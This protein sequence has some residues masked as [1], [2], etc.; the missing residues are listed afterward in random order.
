MIVQAAAA[1]PHMYCTKILH[2][3]QKLLRIRARIEKIDDAKDL[4][5]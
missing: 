5:D 4:Q 3:V 2:F 1:L